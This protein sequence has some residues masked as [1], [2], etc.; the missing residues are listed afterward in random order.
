MYILAYDSETKAL[1]VIQT[2]GLN[3]L[4]GQDL[5]ALK[6][7]DKSDNPLLGSC[8]WIGNFKEILLFL[9]IILKI[10]IDRNKL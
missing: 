6:F 5:S 7:S 8:P 3:C 4:S 9:V 1:R 2:W 10:I